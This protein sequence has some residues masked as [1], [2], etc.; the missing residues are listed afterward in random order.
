MRAYGPAVVVTLALA[1]CP[2]AQK[3]PDKVPT[4]PVLPVLAGTY[5]EE[6]CRK[7]TNADGT[8]SFVKQSWIITPSTWSRDVVV[9]GDDQCTTKQA[10][11]H[12]DGP[13]NVTGP[14]KS[15]PGAFDVDRAFSHRVV[16]AHVDGYIAVLQSYGCGK[17][18]YAVNEPQDVLAGGCK[19]LGL[20]P[21][22]KEHDIVKLDKDTIAF[23][24]RPADND[25]CTPDK[26][27]TELETP[28]KKQ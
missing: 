10:T 6:S 22:D 23:G 25:I 16:T 26:R 2:A 11:I 17:A 19:D 1:G 24:K 9:Y 8:D 13:Y 28:L 21:C 15:V 3:L 27:P 5:A 4:A 18:P 20:M 14:S 7:I 12:A